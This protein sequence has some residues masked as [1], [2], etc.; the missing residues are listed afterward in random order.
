MLDLAVWIRDEYT[1]RDIQDI[2][3]PGDVFHNRFEVA[4]STINTAVQFF[5]IL[6]DFN[7][8]VTIGN[9]DAYY[10]DRSD[11]NSLSIF[12]EWPNITII[13]QL[14]IVEQFDCTYALCPWAVDIDLIPVCDIIFGHFEFN[15]FHLA[16][17][18]I[19]TTGHD[20]GKLSDRCPLIITGHFHMHA[21]RKYDNG[22]IKYLG[23]AYQL[24]WAEAGDDKF[25]YVLDL[26]EGKFEE[27]IRNVGATPLHIR[28]KMSSWIGNDRQFT[29]TSR[30]KGNFINAIIDTEAKKLVSRDGET[31]EVDDTGSVAEDF[32]A[33]I[34]AHNPRDVRVTHA[35]DADGFDTDREFDGIDIPTTIV[36]FVELLDLD[37]PTK[38][39]VSSRTRALYEVTI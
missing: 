28:E 36:E 5:Q 38:D 27:K 25:I 7:I 32:V 8:V 3:I 20:G 24:N 31:F 21:E 23:T 13:D 1:K 26:E 39:A 14:T 34:N 9:H 15:G 19:C 4:V 29:S 37:R 2:V 33:A 18:K 35:N 16:H 10:R 17:Q 22:L 6:K 30:I 12:D 11:V